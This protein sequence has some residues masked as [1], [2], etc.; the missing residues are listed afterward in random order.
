MKSRAGGLNVGVG[1][2][3]HP[4]ESLA[5]ASSLA[6]KLKLRGIPA[7]RR[8]LIPSRCIAR[9]LTSSFPMADGGLPVSD[10]LADEVISLPMHHLSRRTDSGPYRRGGPAE[11]WGS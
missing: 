4:A 7:R 11:R 5:C 3:Y 1:A 2:I 9:P 6:E 10:Q 8:S